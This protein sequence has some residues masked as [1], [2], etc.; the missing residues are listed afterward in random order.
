MPGVFRTNVCPENLSGIFIP[1][2]QWEMP[3]G[4]GNCYS[5]VKLTLV[6]CWGMKIALQCFDDFDHKLSMLWSDRLIW[7]C[8]HSASVIRLR[9]E[10]FP[11]N[12]IVVLFERTYCKPFRHN[13]TI[14]HWLP[15]LLCKVHLRVACPILF[16]PCTSANCSHKVLCQL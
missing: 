7:K 16:I 8:S 10:S 3:T 6:D 14:Y 12:Q 13:C 5:R 2:C 1:L 9:K 11:L 15:L 4:C